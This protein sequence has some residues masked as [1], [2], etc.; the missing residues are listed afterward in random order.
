ML[1]QQHKS[2]QLLLSR[3][4]SKPSFSG[5]TRLKNPVALLMLSI[6]EMLKS[7]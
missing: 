2:W 4:Q 3:K 5:G 6:S 7:L 1:L